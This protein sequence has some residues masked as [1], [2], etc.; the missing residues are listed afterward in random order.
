[1]EA[2]VTPKA[3]PEICNCRWLE[4]SQQHH[5]QRHTSLQT[6][7][8]LRLIDIDEVHRYEVAILASMLTV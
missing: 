2:L 6:L 4:L 7:K 1:M 5:I 3:T 8:P